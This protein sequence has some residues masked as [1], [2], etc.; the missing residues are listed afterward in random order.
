VAQ[1][2]RERDYRATALIGGIDAWQ[3]AGLPLVPV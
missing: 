1:F 3:K 2:L